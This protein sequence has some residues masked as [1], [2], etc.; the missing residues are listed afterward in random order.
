MNEK[1]SF[2][3]VSDALAQK[4]GVSKKVADVFT[5]AF[6]DTVVDAFYM[7]EE[8]VKVKG[9]GTFKLVVVESRESVNVSNGERIVIP[10]YKKVAF[11]PEDSVVE[12]LNPEAEVPVEEDKL[13]V[14]EPPVVEI[15]MADKSSV[16]EETQVVEDE[17]VE[18]EVEVLVQVAEPAHVEEPQDAFSGID[19]LISTPESMEEV[20]QQYEEAKAKMEVAVEE[21][22]KANAEKVRLEKLLAR[23]EANAVPEMVEKGEEVSVMTEVQEDAGEEVSVVEASVQEDKSEEPD[24]AEEDK[25]QEALNRFM[26]ESSRAEEAAVKPKKSH[27]MAW[28]LTIVFVLLA[29]ICFFLYQTFLSIEAVETVPKTEKKEQVKKVNKPAKPKKSETSKQVEQEP[30]ENK[31]EDPEATDKKEEAKPSN[32]TPTKPATYVLQRGESLTRISQ[33]FYG[34]KDSV[35]AIIRVNKFDYPNNLPVGTVVKLP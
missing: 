12:F 31:Q 4:M 27:A 33:K 19:M 9:L 22:R 11:V 6:F 15:P 17:P 32:P 7:G 34:T 24:A 35:P 16:L 13:F 14:E 8:V 3:H 21:A 18:D 5:K 26:N 28:V 29:A 25:H 30:T 2:Q 20:R 23:L 10:G 1:L